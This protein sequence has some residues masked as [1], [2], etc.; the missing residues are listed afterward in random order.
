MGGVKDL[1]RFCGC[2]PSEDSLS[3][4]VYKLKAC[5]NCILDIGLKGKW[6]GDGE[7]I[8]KDLIKLHGKELVAKEWG[9]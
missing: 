5:K 4:A 1:C 7:R 2:D 6:T 9:K 3:E 8:L